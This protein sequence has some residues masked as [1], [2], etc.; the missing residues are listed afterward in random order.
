MIPSQKRPPAHLSAFD[1]DRVAVER[2]SVVAPGPDRRKA[3][4]REPIDPE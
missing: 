1:A 3:A 4:R 2:E